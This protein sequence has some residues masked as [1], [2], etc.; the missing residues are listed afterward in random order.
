M[1]LHVSRMSSVK[2]AV[3]LVI[4][5]ALEALANANIFIN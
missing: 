1:I 2:G 3:S 5:D 4:I